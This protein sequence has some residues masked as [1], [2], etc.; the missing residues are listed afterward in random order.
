MD[1]PL[2]DVSQHLD[3][4]GSRLDSL[5]CTK[6]ELAQLEDADYWLLRSK[7]GNVYYASHMRIT[8]AKKAQ[9]I[10]IIDEMKAFFDIAK[11]GTH[12]ITINSRNYLLFL[13]RPQ[14]PINSSTVDAIRL[15][16]LSVQIAMIYAFRDIFGVTNTNEGSITIDDNNVLRSVRENDSFL[17]KSATKMSTLSAL[18]IKK[19]KLGTINDMLREHFGTDH[20]TT[21]ENF[22]R[23]AS[24]VVER[25]GGNDTLLTELAAQRFLRRLT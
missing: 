9:V 12:Q 15:E 17:L 1:Y 22:R 23:M 2:I 5:S 7:S 8:S 19:W 4:D 20:V 3:W 6:D 25:V 16:N 24:E 14:E 13:Y 18:A 21:L 11:N 10:I